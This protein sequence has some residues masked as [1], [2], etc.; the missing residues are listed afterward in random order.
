[1]LI[2]IYNCFVIPYEASFEPSENPHYKRFEI[3]LDILFGLDVIIC[4]WTTFINKKTGLEIFS[5]WRIA[6][7]YI[8]SGW[9]FIDIV[10]VIP[11]EILYTWFAGEAA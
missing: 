6:W 4:F 2:A 1:M 8:R 5:P 11:I 9:F 7:N 10:A 3:F